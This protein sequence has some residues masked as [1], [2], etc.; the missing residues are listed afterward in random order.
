MVPIETEEEEYLMLRTNFLT[1]GGWDD[2]DF[3]G[4]ITWFD[5]IKNNGWNQTITEFKYSGQTIIDKSDR[6]TVMFETGYPYIGL[7]EE[8]FDKMSEIL[9]MQNYAMNCEKGEHWGLCRAKANDC[10]RLNLDY[11]LTIVIN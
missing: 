10:E 7:S 11:N 4:N 8:Y 5:T 1:L 9:Q 3:T 6:A 2:R